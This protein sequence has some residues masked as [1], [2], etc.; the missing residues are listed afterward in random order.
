MCV[1]TVA[2]QIQYLVRFSVFTILDHYLLVTCIDN[3]TLSKKLHSYV[4]KQEF[5]VL[6]LIH[7]IFFI[8]TKSP[9]VMRFY[10]K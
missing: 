6:F 10:I 1:L 8:I 9:I 4:I 3:Q 2:L 7:T 5:L